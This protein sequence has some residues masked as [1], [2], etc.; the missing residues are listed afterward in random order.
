MT[1]PPLTFEIVI[2]YTVNVENHVFSVIL[3]FSTCPAYCSI[4]RD[5]IKYNFFA[6]A[7]VHGETFAGVGCCA[8]PKV[9]VFKMV[10]GGDLIL[11]TKPYSSLQN[12][13]VIYRE[14]DR[15]VLAGS[16]QYISVNPKSYSNL[17]SSA[18]FKKS[19][20]RRDCT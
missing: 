4:V 8:K 15:S 11:T 19:S 18:L 1:R 14:Y 17:C 7:G 16:G 10:K 13:Q 20:D 2:L 3:F 5:S 12:F 6:V 9:N